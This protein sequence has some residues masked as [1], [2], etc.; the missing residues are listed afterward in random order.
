MRYNY[1]DTDL[2]RLVL[3]RF[4]KEEAAWS[5]FHFLGK[6]ILIHTREEK[7]LQPMCVPLRDE[8]R[9]ERVGRGGERLQN[10]KKNNK[11]LKKKTQVL[12]WTKDHIFSRMRRRNI[13]SGLAFTGAGKCSSSRFGL[14]SLF[15]ECTISRIYS[16]PIRYRTSRSTYDKRK[17]KED[18]LLSKVSGGFRNEIAFN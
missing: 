16:I 4:R 10:N 1:D 12:I 6:I 11:T 5:V 15:P 8:R 14:R 13:L 3:K 2:A 18:T 17:D 9:G 7:D